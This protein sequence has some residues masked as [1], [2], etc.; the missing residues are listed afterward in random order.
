MIDLRKQSIR[1]WYQQ[2]RESSDDERLWISRGPEFLI[3]IE[4]MMQAF[5]TV[6]GTDHMR[7]I[8]PERF[9]RFNQMADGTYPYQPT[10]EIKPGGAQPMG[11]P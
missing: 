3:Q 10:P 2:C 7:S 8:E 11:A 9:T 5:Y 1:C 4:G 6:H